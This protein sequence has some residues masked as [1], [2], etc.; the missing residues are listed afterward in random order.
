[1]QAVLLSSDLMLIASAQGAADRRGVGLVTASS[2]DQNPTG[3]SPA[4]SL[5]L[6]DLRAVGLDIAET[7]PRIRNSYP[8]ARIVACGPHVHKQS[9]EAAA[10]AGCDEVITRGEFERCFDNLLAQITASADPK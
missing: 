5:V 7:V 9:L 4:A 8:K 10:D 3:S 6:I 2:F 1:M